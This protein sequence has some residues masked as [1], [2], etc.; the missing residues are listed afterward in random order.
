MELTRKLAVA[1]A[2]GRPSALRN[3]FLSPRSGVLL[4]VL[5]LVFWEVSARSGLV[6]SQNWP[7]V[8]VVFVTLAYN[9]IH[10]GDVW[11]A[12]GG[13]LYRALAGLIIGSAIGILFGV[14]MG[15]V[16]LIRR[17]IEPTIE[18]L[19]P[20]PVPALIPPLVLFLGLEDRMKITLVALSAFFPVL[21]NTLQGV[22]A[23]EPTYRAVAATFGVPWRRTV[24]LVLM[25]AIL[26]YILAGMR[27]SLGLSVIVAVVAE[28][29]AGSDGIGYYLMSME[30]AERPADMYGAL[31]LL[32]FSG[33]ALNW[34][35]VKME[36]RVLY[37][38][39]QS[40]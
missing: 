19:R 1:E 30:Y 8:S 3:F 35:F 7:P 23:L 29:I 5:L 28:M 15:T 33:Y 14:L 40:S 11:P 31:L 16:S 34:I 24:R 36:K 21:I 25:P 4:I 27:T 18:L 13:T 32:A 26:P 12:L 22:I 20:L 2:P 10:G 9:L 38:Y 39:D 37:W 6:L 17:T